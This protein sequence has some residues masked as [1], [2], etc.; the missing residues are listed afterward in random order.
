[1][2]TH[3]KGTKNLITDI[4]KD[5]S[6]FFPDEF[7]MFKKHMAESVKDSINDYAEIKHVDTL[8]RKLFEMPETL[9]SMMKKRLPQD[10][11]DWFRSLDG[12][13]WFAKKF[14]QFRSSQK[15]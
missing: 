1:M 8:E 3:N 5:Y 6:T 4:V 9:F 10:D 12:S 7:A 15:S 13:R 2:N 11:W 14:K